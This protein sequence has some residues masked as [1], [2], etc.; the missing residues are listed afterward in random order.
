MDHAR[1]SRCRNVASEDC[2]ALVVAA[3][4]DPGRREELIEEFR[5]LIAAVARP[6][7]RHGLI[8][9]HELMQQGVVG[10]LEA[11]K[12]YDPSL[13]TPF[14]A[15]ASWWVR[16]AMQQVTSELDGPIVLSDRARRALSRLATA[17]RAHLQ[18]HRREPTHTELAAAA[19]LDV[20]HVDSLL[21]ARR[22]ARALE[23]RIG[24]DGLCFGDLLADPHAEDELERVPRRAAANGVP[25]LL[26]LLGDRER[27][28]VSRRFGL[29]GEA[30]TLRDIAADLGLSAERVRQIEERALERLRT[31]CLATGVAASPTDDREVL[32]SR[33]EAGA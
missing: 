2:S 25:A 5:P 3:K 29:D 19:Q 17:R 13:G 26:A 10:L 33:A 31:A 8:A 12:R 22:P 14:W 23:E 18:E 4:V 21:A 1:A 28:V 16:Q 9:R 11:L 6:Y 20:V 32:Q 7:C 27:L 24:D 15:Y 30:C